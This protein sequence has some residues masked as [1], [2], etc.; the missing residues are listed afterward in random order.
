VKRV[1]LHVDL[2]VLDPVVGQANEFAPP[3][4]FTRGELL[5]AVRLVGERFGIA[6]AGIASYDP[7]L[8]GDGVVFSAAVATLDAITD[9]PV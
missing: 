8:D 7:S 1:Y 6:G 4:G 9:A 2:D 5:D 3:G